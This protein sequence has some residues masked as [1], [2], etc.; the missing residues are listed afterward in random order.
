M[1]FTNIAFCI[2]VAKSDSAVVVSIAFVEKWGSSGFVG[3]LPWKIELGQHP[4][5]EEHEVLWMNVASGTYLC[6]SDHCSLV[7]RFRILLRGP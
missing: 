3:S 5:E 6:Q 7:F 2:A 4:I 1:N